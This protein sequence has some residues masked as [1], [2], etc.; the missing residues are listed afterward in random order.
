MDLPGL[1]LHRPRRVL[2]RVADQVGQH[3]AEVGRLAK[4]RRQRLGQVDPHRRGPLRVAVIQDGEHPS[5]RGGEVDRFRRRLEVPRLELG[6]DQLA[7]DQAEQAVRGLVGLL[8]QGP[9]P[10]G[11][12][13]L[14]PLHD[15][16]QR[17]LHRGRR[18]AHLMP[19]RAQH[20]VL[21]FQ[22][23]P[24]RGDILVQGQHAGR[25][26]LESRDDDPPD[27]D[28][29]VGILHPQLQG[30]FGVGVLGGRGAGCGE[31]LVGGA[32][33]H[34]GGLEAV[35]GLDLRVGV[36]DAPGRVLQHHADRRVAKDRVHH[37][38]LAVEGVDELELAEQ[39]GC[40]A[41][42]H[43]REPAGLRGARRH[44]RHQQPREPAFDLDRDGEGVLR[45]AQQVEQRAQAAPA[46]RRRE[47]AQQ[48]GAV[49][50]RH[51]RRDVAV[52]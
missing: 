51:L 3:L 22:G 48:L 35:D 10:R 19:D 21:C 38:A 46:S 18:A 20:Q 50:D 39:D 29:A 43:R 33:W 30:A 49:G 2:E 31:D 52:V 6:D 25:L 42:E 15:P 26:A 44:P 13:R 41:G 47:G 4:S 45:S 7:F 37:P 14:V 9:A 23:L 1:D 8:Q 16:G 34:L 12:D 17:V 5:H 27:V 40:L 32:A 24:L 36:N 11:V 28:G